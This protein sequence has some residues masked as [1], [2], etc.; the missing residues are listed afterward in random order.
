MHSQD[1][2][3]RD[4]TVNLAGQCPDQGPGLLLE[5][6]VRLCYL[7]WIAARQVWAARFGVKVVHEARSI[8]L[9]DWFDS[10]PESPLDVRTGPT[11]VVA[12][13][14]EFAGVV[15]WDVFDQGDHPFTEEGVA[16]PPRR[17]GK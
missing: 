6:S 17:P 1:D 5:L 10:F 3:E 2:L 15:R 14:V 8:Q 13:N 12:R 11:E 16:T 7:D 9:I 4:R